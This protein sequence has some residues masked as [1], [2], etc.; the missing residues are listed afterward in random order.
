MRSTAMT[1][2][3]IPISPAALGFIP[4]TEELI[5]LCRRTLTENR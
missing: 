5:P 3:R 2:I 4:H 1:N